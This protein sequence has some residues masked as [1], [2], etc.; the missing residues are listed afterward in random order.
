MMYGCGFN[1]DLGRHH[2]HPDPVSILFPIFPAN[3]FQENS[4]VLHLSVAPEWSRRDKTRT[5][6]GEA[7]FRHVLKD[8]W[9]M[10]LCFHLKSGRKIESSCHSSTEMSLTRIHEDEGSIPGFVHWVKDLALQ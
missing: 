7:L 4:V 9:R 6:E 2:D 3:D 10:V 5:R 8:S 1:F